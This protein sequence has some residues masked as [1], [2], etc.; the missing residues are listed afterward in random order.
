MATIQE[1][2][3]EFFA[4]EERGNLAISR[5]VNRVPQDTEKAQLFFEESQKEY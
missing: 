1:A 5:R 3:S 2:V 4:A